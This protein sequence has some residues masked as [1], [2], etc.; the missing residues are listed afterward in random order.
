[1][2]AR[3]FRPLIALVCVCLCFAGAARANPSEDKGSPPPARSG[4]KN[5]CG[6]PSA[7]HARCHAQVVTEEGSAKP[8]ATTSYRY[9]YSP[10]D[11]RSAYLLPS[12]G[13]AGHTIA[14]VDAYD[15]PRAE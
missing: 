2:S 15:D 13:G 7:N 12:T 3:L 6:P 4:H 9:G 5:V 10:A 1:M 14:I 11:L 8:L